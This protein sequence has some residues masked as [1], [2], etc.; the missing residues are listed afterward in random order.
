MPYWFRPNLNGQFNLKGDRKMSSNQTTF[1]LP[2][3]LAINL[4]TEDMIVGCEVE[5]KLFFV[6]FYGFNIE[7]LP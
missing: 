3:A 5:Y 6:I 1:D 2:L 7:D 4:I